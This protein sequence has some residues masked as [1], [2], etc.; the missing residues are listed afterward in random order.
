MAPTP[1]TR[2]KMIDVARKLF[3]GQGIQATTMHNIA[4]ASGH[5]RRTLYTYFRSKDEIFQAVVERELEYLRHEVEI[6]RR[7]MLPPEQKLLN[8]IYVHLE[9]MKTIV[10]RNGSLKSEF[11]RDIWLVEKA[12]MPL[13]KYEQA[14]IQDILD[15]G[16]L[17]GD[18]DI[19][20]SATMAYLIYHSIKGMEISYISGHLRQSGAKVYELVRENMMHLI[21]QGIRKKQ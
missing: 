14:L 10:M 12:R 9:A 1:T 4:D 13:D 20:D 11:F 19:P 15:E 21:L 7:I 18:F 3:A 2:E 6:A 5:G 8:L 17:N 16:V